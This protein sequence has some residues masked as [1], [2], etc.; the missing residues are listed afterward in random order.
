M[1]GSETFLLRFR[2]PEIWA[3]SFIAERCEE[4]GCAKGR[5]M[6]SKGVGLHVLTVTQWETR[7]I[8][9]GSNEDKCR[10]EADIATVKQMTS[11]RARREQI[12][13]SVSFRR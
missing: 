7:K 13:K 12:N 4:E 10:R 11:L 6:N 9:G 3:P 5:V 1:T 8:A 2:A